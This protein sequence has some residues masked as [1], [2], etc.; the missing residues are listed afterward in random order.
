ML[1]LILF[2]LFPIRFCYLSNNL[3]STV[4]IINFLSTD[5]TYKIEI[6]GSTFCYNQSC[7]GDSEAIIIELGNMSDFSTFCVR[8]QVYILEYEL[9]L[10]TSR[11][12]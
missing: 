9:M 8:T 7:H 11:E 6:A 2:T 10:Q 1:T 4:L 3:N 5:T 12:E